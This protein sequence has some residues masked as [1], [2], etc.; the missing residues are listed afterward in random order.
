M[1]MVQHGSEYR[2]TFRQAGLVRRVHDEYEPV[3]LV[4][5]FWPDTA[6]ALAT[7]Q[8]VNCDMVALIK[9]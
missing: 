4:V 7:P 3:N 1:M 8:V 6:E 2:G 5:V 9:T